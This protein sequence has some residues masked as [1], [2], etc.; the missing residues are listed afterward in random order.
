MKNMGFLALEAPSKCKFKI[1]QRGPIYRQ[2]LMC[3]TG[4]V[5]SIPGRVLER[6]AIDHT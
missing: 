3:K 1:E 2:N 6:S 5:H 4:K